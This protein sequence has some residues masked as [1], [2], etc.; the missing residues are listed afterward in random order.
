MMDSFVFCP[1]KHSIAA[2]DAGTCSGNNGISC[3]CKQDRI[4]ALNAAVEAVTSKFS[5]VH[6][7]KTS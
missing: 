4:G 2:H 3:F 1:C 7:Q 6:M 5:E